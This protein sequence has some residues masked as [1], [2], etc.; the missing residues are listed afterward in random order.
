MMR[1]PYC[2]AGIESR[3][4]GVRCARCQAPHHRV[5]WTEYGK[6]CVYGCGA[7]ENRLLGKLGTA[8]IVLAAGK[9]AVKLAL[10]GARERLGGKSV[11]ALFALSCA[12][13]GL[14]LA[15]LLHHVHASHKVDYE[16]LLGGLFLVLATWITA[17][18]YR[19]SHLEDDMNLKVGERGLG[20]YYF[21]MPAS[22]SGSA[23]G[24]GDPGC[25][26]MRGC[27]SSSSGS[28]SL[29]G[30]DEFLGAILIAIL[31]VIIIIVV[32]P[33][34]AWLAVEVLYPCVV[35]AVYFALYGSLAFAVNNQQDLAGKLFPCLL[36]SLRYAF[37]YTSVV[38]ALILVAV[39]L[40]HAFA[41][42]H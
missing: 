16:F 21:F 28:S 5:C 41:P 18:L 11:V 12:V 39:K 26:S 3:D 10:V 32:L 34:V 13:P 14:A 15:P 23:S 36:R 35:L 7:T 9:N 19:G 22:S 4:D 24:C 30:A 25:G 38:A 27:S 31:A 40:F 33:F 37:L 29:G 17:L 2:H 42:P 1:C 8:R 20:T 6:C